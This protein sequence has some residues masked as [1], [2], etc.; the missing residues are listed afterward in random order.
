MAQPH[1]LSRVGAGRGKSG[2]WFAGAMLAVVCG[3]FVLN[4]LAVYSGLNHVGPMTMYSGLT[5]DGDNHLLI[6]T[7]PLSEEHAYVAILRVEAARDRRAP[8]VAL[9]NRLATREGGERPLVHF[10]VVR[11]QASRACAVAPNVRL[12]LTLQTSAGRTLAVENACADPTM[13]RPDVVTS[14]SV[15]KNRPCR[16]ALEEWLEDVSPET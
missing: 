7:I 1:L 11:H 13:L 10:N 14:Y 5:D 6:P 2:A 15:C 8:A 3:A 9:L 4:N 12:S 16:R